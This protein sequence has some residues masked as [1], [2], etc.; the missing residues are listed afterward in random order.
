MTAPEKWI[1][2]CAAEDLTP[3]IG[4]CA[5][6]EDK[7]IAIFKLANVD[8]VFAIDNHDPFS[9]A[10]VLSRGLVGDLQGQYVVASPIYKQHFN[11]KTG[12][13]LEDETVTLNTYAVREN[14]GKIE[15]GV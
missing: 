8:G 5:L 12:A 4:A 11:L 3:N 6:V 13:C 10:N 1:S 14:D 2:V 9:N 15:I 7:Q